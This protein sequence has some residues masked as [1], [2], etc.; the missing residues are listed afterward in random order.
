MGWKTSMIIVNSDNEFDK[1]E[2]F[3]SLGY[4]KL[5]SIDKQYFESVINPDDEK[6]YIGK[7]NGNTI[8]CIQDLP[9]E[10]LDSTVSRAERILSTKFPDT[11]IV[12]FALH[13]VVN[14]WGYSI[15]NN[16]KK[17]RVRAGSSEG[18][19][20]VEFG[21]ITEEEKELFSKSKLNSTGERV[22]VFDTMP[23]E[24]FQDDQVGENFV[25]DISKKY[26]GEKLDAC[27]EL[28]FETQFSGYTFS[29]SKPQKKIEHQIEYQ[30]KQTQKKIIHKKPWWKFW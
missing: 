2:I 9:L 29:K 18:G 8:I 1:D 30:T 20:M 14:L 23:D 28:L 26:L 25:F 6:I 24:E 5:K 27:D 4:Y 3:E 19:T 17:L 11:D 15:V 10:S 21:E 7:Y 16:G 12:T 13:S 22:F